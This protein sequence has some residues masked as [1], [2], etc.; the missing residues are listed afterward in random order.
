MWI[1][2]GMPCTLVQIWWFFEL[3][4]FNGR[5]IRCDA[6]VESDADLMDVAEHSLV[7]IGACLRQV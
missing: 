3:C 2:L 6:A 4:H 5:L 1:G 7:S